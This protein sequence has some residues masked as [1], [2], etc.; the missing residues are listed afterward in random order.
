MTPAPRHASRG[1]SLWQAT[2]GD[3]EPAAPR[4]PLPGPTSVDV[5]IVG[6]G[7][8]GLWT[9]YYLRRLDPTLRVAVLEREV[10]GFGASG[11][12]GGWCS[13]LLPV[14]LDR[15]AAASTREG[16][17]RWQ[18]AM[19][20]TVDEVGT[21]AAEEDIDA[22][23]AKAGTIE[24]ARS[25]VQAQRAAE[26]VAEDHDWGLSTDDVALLDS[27]SAR[28]LLNATDTVAGV[29][30]PHCAT[31]HPARLV[32]GLA[33]AVERHGAV[34]HEQTPVTRIEPGR[35]LTA[36]GDVRAE[37]V[38]RATEGY[39][40]DLPGARR[41]I[42]PIYS[43]MIATEPLPHAVWDGVGL[44]DRPTFT[45]LRHMVVYGQRTA[46]GRLAFGGR[47]ARYRL[48][49]RVTPAQDVVPPVWA[50]LER[51]LRDMLPDI[52]DA[53]VTHRWAGPLGTHRDWWPSVGLHR[54]SGLAWAGGY[55]GDGVAASNLAG[56][57]LAD[58]VLDRATDRVSLPWVGHRSP[59]WEPEPL[60]W[61][62][63][64]TGLTAMGWA[65]PEESA[66]GRTSLVARAFGRLMH[67]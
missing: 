26:R 34:V 48:S 30:S 49:S 66:T 24:V 15:V 40:P 38:V 12:N 55:V 11:R 3:E 46:D 28:R 33:R 19:F 59:A 35:V 64:N 45:D 42:A 60:R 44:A 31:V 58:L 67:G 51:T 57:T 41:Q 56:R 27:R 62:G 47:G 39:T 54:R 32:R 4:A 63:I 25:P 65:D 50:W 2:L 21:V 6:A 43:A 13:A 53:A 16:A 8:T 36:A 17:V 9:A 14:A 7:Y 1:L 61:V 22:H 10:A 18:R 52:S 23:W 20:A 29:W 37:V 5:A